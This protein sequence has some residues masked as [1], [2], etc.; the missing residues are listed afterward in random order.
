MKLYFG[1][2]CRLQDHLSKDPKPKS[3][4]PGSTQLDSLKRSLS[5]TV[6]CRTF[7]WL[8][9]D[10]REAAK[11]S[12]DVK[13]NVSLQERVVRTKRDEFGLGL[14]TIICRWSLTLQCGVRLLKR[15]STPHQAVP[16]LYQQAG[17][18]PAPQSDPGSF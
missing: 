7:R 13:S 18:G 5:A 1:S 6:Q 3:L 4:S 11:P 8:S 2:S 12:I 9:T 17:G 15:S 14:P 16:C 10:L